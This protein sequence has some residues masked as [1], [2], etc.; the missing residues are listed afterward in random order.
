MKSV[1]AEC[2]DM[3]PT[4]SENLAPENLIVQLVKAVVAT[5]AKMV[6]TAVGILVPRAIIAALGS[7]VWMDF[8]IRLITYLAYTILFLFLS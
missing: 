3:V 6:M 4:V 2:V 8:A 5:C 7:I 1:V